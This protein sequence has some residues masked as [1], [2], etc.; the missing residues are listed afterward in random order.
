MS[1]GFPGLLRDS[2]FLSPFFLPVGITSSEFETAF[3]C[4][5]FSCQLDSDRKKAGRKKDPKIYFTL[6]LLFGSLLR[7]GVQLQP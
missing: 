4:P 7:P 1:S 3:S 2:F 5:P 6:Y